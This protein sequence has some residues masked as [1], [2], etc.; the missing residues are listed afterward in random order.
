MAPIKGPLR[1]QDI[2]VLSRSELFLAEDQVAAEGLE[3]DRTG[4]QTGTFLKKDGLV[5]K[6]KACA[7]A[8]KF[9]MLLLSRA[10]FGLKD[11]R[12]LKR[13]LKHHSQTVLSFE[14]SKSPTSRCLANQH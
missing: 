13:A 12:I 1:E 8:R 3:L 2:R 6:L 5:E 14:T 9:H 7:W 11:S 10:V 4:P